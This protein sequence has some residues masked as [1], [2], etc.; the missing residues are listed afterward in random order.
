MTEMM[1]LLFD[2]YTQ[3]MP[4]KR[5]EKEEQEAAFWYERLKELAGE[6]EALDIWDA[7]TGEAAVTEERCFLAGVKTGLTLAAELMLL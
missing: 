5:A 2:H 7:A 4:Y 3:G 1:D 6:E